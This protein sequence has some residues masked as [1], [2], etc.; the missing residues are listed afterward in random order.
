MV[1]GLAIVVAAGVGAAAVG[2]GVGPGAGECSVVVSERPSSGRVGVVEVVSGGCS[3]MPVAVC[4]E[5]SL[6]LMVLSETKRKKRNGLAS[7]TTSTPW[8]S[9]LSTAETFQKIPSLLSSSS[10]SRTVSS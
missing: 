7:K 9:G 5:A 1:A 3:S 8:A 4:S 2:L 6:G 10:L